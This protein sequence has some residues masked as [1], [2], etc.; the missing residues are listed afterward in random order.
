MTEFPADT[1]GVSQI[2]CRVVPVD[3][4]PPEKV[5]RSEAAVVAAAT[6]R[7]RGSRR[8]PLGE[9]TINYVAPCIITAEGKVNIR[10][11]CS[12]PCLRCRDGQVGCRTRVEWQI[13]RAVGKA[14]CVV[15]SGVEARVHHSAFKRLA[16]P[17]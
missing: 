3:E 4:Q 16:I 8:R 11:G 15:C 14:E 17:P 2:E 12:D 7:K 5:V 9:V 13:V 6:V 10:G 1:V